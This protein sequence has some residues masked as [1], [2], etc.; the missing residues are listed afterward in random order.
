MPYEDFTTFTEVESTGNNF[1]SQTSTRN[2]F[3]GIIGTDD[4]HVYKDFGAGYFGDYEHWLDIEITSITGSN[5]RAIIWAVS[6]A[7]GAYDVSVGQILQIRTS[8]GTKFSIYLTDKGNSNEVSAYGLFDPNTSYYIKIYR[9]GTSV[10]FKVYPSASDRENDTNVITT[11]SITGQTTTWRYLYGGMGGKFGS[12]NPLSGYVKNLDLNEGVEE[13]DTLSVSDSIILNLSKESQ[14]ESD[15]INLTDEIHINFITQQEEVDTFTLNDEI[16]FLIS[17]NLADPLSLS[18]VIQVDAIETSIN[19]LNNK[20]AM[21]NG[22]LLDLNNDI[23]T[24][25]EEKSNLKNDVRF[26]KL[27]QVAGEAGYQSLGKTYIKVFIDSVEQT[28]VDV[29]TITIS[30]SLNSPHTASFVLGRAYDDTKPSM[31]TYIEITYDTWVLYTGYIT[32]ITPTDSPD[33]I[34]IMCQD[35]YW[36]QNKTQK[37]F[38]IGHKPTDDRELYY[39]TISEALT[40]CGV[41]FGIGNFIPQTMNCFGE[42]TSNCIS[43]L[44]TNAGNYGWFYDVDT[45]KKLWV[46]EA[47]SVVTLERQEI[48]KNIGL[49]QVLRHSFRESIENI[50]NKFRVQMG[51]ITVRK[52]SNGGGSKEYVGYNYRYFNSSASPAWD[53]TYERLAI[54]SDDDSGLF[55]HPVSQNELYK[56]V[57]TKYSLPALNSELESWTDRFPPLVTVTI[58]FGFWQPSLGV[59][60]K[61]LSGE[62]GNLTEG[63]TIDYENGILQFNEPIYLFETDAETGQMTNIRRPTIH[64]QL[65]KKQYHSNTETPATNPETTISNPLM[66]F[67]DKK[68]DY[69]E[70]ILKNLE[71]GGLGIQVGGWYISGYDDEENPIWKY[72]PSWDDTAF[73]N[74]LVNWQLSKRCD[75]RITG[76][77][78]LTIDALC[79]YDIDLTNR[80]SIPGVTDSALNIKTINYNIGSWRAT[81]QLENDKYYNRSVSIPSHGE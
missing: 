33:S 60:N 52:F 58:P 67:T 50:V 48:D 71:L 76:E 79:F 41:D 5:D 53:T 36:K 2:T 74:D 75:V 29:N 28:D 80:V 18:D 70:T 47:G 45:T 4:S 26:L 25:R 78:E 22:N 11:Q 51:N 77:V 42:G 37:Y 30:K 16:E 15:T 3:T 62:I 73:A 66:F 31:E 44:I 57:F 69:P 20:F 68:G 35:E 39:N 65:W 34:K 6:N 10:T 38:H 1:W 61:I 59:S 64:L 43:Q 23:R 24:L 46:A 56:D 14:E 72:V 40:A 12:S 49:Y 54:N 9:S 19:D 63:F 27:Y 81:L 32:Q 17:T 8:S 55:H 7:I 21:V 13:E